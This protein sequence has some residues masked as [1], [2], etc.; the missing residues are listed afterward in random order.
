[1]FWQDVGVTG[2]EK[3]GGLNLFKW[4]QIK[5]SFFAVFPPAPSGKL[6]VWRKVTPALWGRNVTLFWKQEAGF[7]ANG[8][9]ISYEVSWENA[10][11]RSKPE[12]ISL[13]SDCNST[14]IF[15]DNH[16]HRVSI[17]ARNNVGYSHPSVLIIPG[18]TD[19][20]KKLNSSELK[21][22]HVNGTDG[23]IL[24]SW[25]PRDKSDSY[26]IDWCNFPM[27]QPC[28]L[29]WKRFGPSTSSA[30][31]KSAAFVPGV[32]YNFHVYASAAN[33]AFLLEKKTGYLKELRKLEM[34]FKFM[35]LLNSSVINRG[36]AQPCFCD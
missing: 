14:R 18:A 34:H 2:K 15:I 30:L 17:M 9:I 10:V 19:T 32:R 13:S 35:Y 6:D 26:I 23:G 20:E 31:I 8:E 5:H 24:I 3:S 12:H 27:L 1:M 36:I 33:R 29:Q 11:D 22:E 28:D 21:E 7:Q 16:P 25:K 4:R